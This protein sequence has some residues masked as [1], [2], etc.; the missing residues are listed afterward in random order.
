M[1]T[2]HIY[3]TIYITAQTPWA[4]K[5]ITGDITQKQIDIDI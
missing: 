2:V 3:F 4:G 5:N 1:P